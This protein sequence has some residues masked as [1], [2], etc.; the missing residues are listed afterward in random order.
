MALSITGLNA[1]GEISERETQ[2]CADMVQVVS[3]M[4]L[5]EFIAAV[6]R[7]V[8]D[9]IA[10]LTLKMRIATELGTTLN[11]ERFKQLTIATLAANEK[12]A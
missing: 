2:L 5:D 4:L 11:P 3:K 12:T 8:P 6:E 9:D 7:V 10:G 1:Y